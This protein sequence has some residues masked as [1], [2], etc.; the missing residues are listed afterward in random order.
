M[1]AVVVGG[2]AAGMTAASRIRRL[3]P[4]WEVEVYEE[5]SYV[6]HAPCGIPYFVEGL[7]KDK[8]ELTMYSP[9][10]FRKKRKIEVF[11]NSKVLK[12]DH[13]ARKLIVLKN[14]RERE[15]NYDKLIIATGAKPLIPNP[16]WLEVEKVFTIRHIEDGVSIRKRILKDKEVVV[17]GAGYI[18]IELSEALRKLGKKVTLVEAMDQIMPMFD[19]EVALDIEEYMRKRGVKIRK[20][21]KVVDISQRRNGVLVETEKGSYK[22]DSVILAIG[23]KPNV[24]LALMAGARRGETG[25]IYVDDRMWTGVEDLYAAGDN[26]EVLNLVTGRRSYM[27]LAPLANKEGFVAGDNVAGGSLRFPGA[28]GS[29][30][31]KFYSLEIGIT[32]ISEANARELGFKVKSVYISHSSKAHY[33]PGSKWIKVKLVVEEGSKRVLG[34]QI[35]G[36]E[37]VWGRIS[38]LAVA[39]Q[40]RMKVDDLFFADIPYAPPFSPV[41]DP[42]IVAARVAR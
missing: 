18:G 2:G 12:I 25:A 1:K 5:T 41:W 4:T 35:I 15:V 23:V 14:G 17:I 16:K 3:Q 24:D 13:K 38:A 26:V 40:N 39:I 29:A 34:G 32:G 36:L 33:Y 7:V 6:S 27:P 19:K 20:G 11:T 30:I 21:E 8:G 28:V 10:F 37:G 22:A 42:L 31:T 9:E